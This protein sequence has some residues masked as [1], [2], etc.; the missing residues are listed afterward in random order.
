MKLKDMQSKS[1]SAGV[2]TTSSSQIGK[3]S[4]NVDNNAR[5]ED[6]LKEFQSR[7]E[8]SSIEVREAID[9]KVRAE[10]KLFKV[11]HEL[12][13]LKNSA[14]PSEDRGSATQ[15]AEKCISLEN[16]L[17]KS[18]RAHEKLENKVKNQ[19]LLE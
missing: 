18:T 13:S 14:V 7:I 15:L 11:E 6:K 3:N 9:A 12:K 1:S 19:L 10:S 2:S 17:K 16:S 5:M 4:S 8:Q